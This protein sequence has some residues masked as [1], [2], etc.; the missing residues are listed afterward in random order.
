MLEGQLGSCL[1]ARL[2][3]YHQIYG[4]GTLQ[5]ISYNF[6]S[7][8]GHSMG[9]PMW[10]PLT[11]QT[12]T[13]GFYLYLPFYRKNLGQDADK[14]STGRV[15]ANQSRVVYL[16]SQGGCKAVQ[17]A[18]GRTGG[19]GGDP[20]QHVYWGQGASWS[21]QDQAFPPLELCA[22]HGDRAETRTQAELSSLSAWLL[23]SLH[24][25]TYRVTQEA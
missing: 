25:E 19:R 21:A 23:W 8:A 13:T 15:L 17:T 3:C 16:E 24:S 14:V 9:W 10:V 18:G 1:V 7:L 22:W 11:N 2:F 6:P 12:C 4:W 5:P 20:F